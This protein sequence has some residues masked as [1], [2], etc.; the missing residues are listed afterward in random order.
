MRVKYWSRAGLML[1]YWCNA[2]CASCYLRCSPD[3]HVSIDVD[4]T[5]KFWQ[6]LQEFSPHGCR[7]HLSGG[8]PFGDFPGLLDLCTRAQAAGLG[9]LEKIE[10]N[11]FW[12]TDETEVQRR[13]QLLAEAGM[14]KLS[15]SADPYHQQFVPIERPRLAARVAQAVLGPDG[16]QVRWRDWLERGC[17]TAKLGFAELRKEIANYIVQRRDRYNGRAAIELAPLVE[18]KSLAELADNSC[19]EPLLRSKH[20]HIDADGRI[21]PGTCAGIVL[22]RLADS[23]TVAEVWQR[24]WDDAENRTVLGALIAGG[25][26]ELARRSG[27]D[28]M[29]AGETFAGKCHLCWCVRSLLAGRGECPDELGPQWMLRPAEATQTG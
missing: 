8:E 12:A 28:A 29:L 25:P 5:L 13:V 15:I 4:N 9:P 14:E 3:H 17:T 1:T 6:E 21:M 7:V 26:A 10:T 20:V 11:A 19:R 22:G 27:M 24:L 16:V 23:T 18:R 2:R